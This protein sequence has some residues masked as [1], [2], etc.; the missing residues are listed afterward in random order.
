MHVLYLQFVIQNPHGILIVAA[1][2]P[3]C[4][5]VLGLAY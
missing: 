3:G 5:R 1:T 4:C 2:T